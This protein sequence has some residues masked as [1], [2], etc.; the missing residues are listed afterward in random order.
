MYDAAP[1][2][3]VLVTIKFTPALHMLNIV[4]LAA[5][6]NEFSFK[7]PI[8]NQVN[9]AGPM[10]FLPEQNVGVDI[11]QNAMPRMQMYSADLCKEVLFQEDRISV[12]WNRRTGYDQP[13]M[14]PGFEE[15]AQDLSSAV[16]ILRSFLLTNFGVGIASDTAEIAYTNVIA[17]DSDSLG[18]SIARNFSIIAQSQFNEANAMNFAWQEPLSIQGSLGFA[19][20]SILGPEMTVLQRPAAI[21]Q[22]SANF[23]SMD[24]DWPEL[25]ARLLIAREVLSRRFKTLVNPAAYAISA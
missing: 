16:S 15:I 23:A 10:G 24:T 18:E 25:P 20:Y 4:N 13:P 11:G 3:Q 17:I 1:I 8:F 19:Q 9:R 12:G 22:L 6:R 2:K 14:Y 7:Y 21:L 5:F